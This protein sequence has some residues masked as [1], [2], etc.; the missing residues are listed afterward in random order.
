ML[1]SNKRGRYPEF[2]DVSGRVKQDAEYERKKTRNE[3]IIE[4]I[5]DSYD[6][7]IVYDRKSEDSRNKKE[8]PLSENLTRN[9][10]NK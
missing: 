6:V 1:T 4:D 3:E 10:S 5:I 2:K 7:R 8:I 9:P